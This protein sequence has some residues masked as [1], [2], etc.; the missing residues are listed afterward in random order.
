[1]SGFGTGHDLGLQPHDRT[2][3]AC[4][5]RHV[6][7]VPISLDAPGATG[8]VAMRRRLIA[9]ISTGLILL[10]ALMFWSRA[11]TPSDGTVVQLSNA[12]FHSDRMTLTFVLD[13]GT[14]LRDGDVVTAVDGIP[15][16]SYAPDRAGRKGDVLTYSVLRHGAPIHVTIRLGNFPVLGFLARSW[17]SLA[18]LFILLSMAIFV[19]HRRAADPAAQ[20]LILIASLTFCGT[21][22]WLLG[23]QTFRLAAHGPTP[24]DAVGELSLAMIWG[25]VAH[26]ALVAPATKLRVSWWRIT[27]LYSLPLVLYGIYL[28]FALPAAHDAVEVRGRIAQISL[29]PSSVLPLATALLLL[30]SYR[31]TDDA[32]SRQRMRWLLL[33]LLAAGL[34]FLT[35]WTIPNLMGWQVPPA[36]LIALLWLPP[37]LAVGAAIL[38]YR[39]FDIEVIVRRSLLYA[40]LT[41]SVVGI[42]LAGAWVLSRLFT[43]PGLAALLACGLVGF[44]APPLHSFLRRRV[45]RLVYGER[46][47]PF[48]VLARLGR[49]DVGADP[50]L[51]LQR[52]A[53][54]LAQTLRLPFVAIELRRAQSRFAVEASYGHDSGR[55]VT[56][57]LTLA[58]GALG[59]LILA[60]GPGREP[61]GPADRRLLD[62]LTR[63]VSRAASLVLLAT[64]LQ[65][66]REQIV[67]AR[68]EER[69]RLHHRLHD[70]LGPDLAAGV[71]RMEAARELIA[72]DADAAVRHLEE[73]IALTRSLIG[74]VRGLVYNL[75]PPALDQ[76]G[77]AGALRERTS[78]LSQ[79]DAPGGIRVLIQQEG[80]LDDLPAAV[81]VA[82]FWI[83]VE[84][85]S[86]A[87]RH[88]QVSSCWVCL[89]RRDAVLSIEIRDDGRGL[90]DRV[91][92][93]GGL[94]S[95]RER[96][97][98]LGGTCR[99]RRGE[100]GGTV[101]EARLPIKE[102]KVPDEL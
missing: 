57:P 54:T 20:A 3:S 35:I 87:I 61:F 86:N 47:D 48:E 14:G 75:R 85:V 96:T 9:A 46:D 73:Q 11:V 84:A 79:P 51:V 1:M 25:A 91:R 33:T 13:A 76:L 58:D 42:Y 101:V 74:D 100:S 40:S 80:V 83:G 89:S 10:S 92:A 18:V 29:L 77:L 72:R 66:S 5:P 23:D 64:E 98:E 30:L 55:S 24:L 19:F 82:A 37:T 59:R 28:A 32:E 36:N 4:Q 88:A 2:T 56:V 38:R 99:V 50:R 17:T 31:A 52:V 12:P 49:I 44:I 102:A 21:L 68:E 43:R 62:T 16:R 22:A 95:M 93:G 63:Q 90:P 60:V 97:E 39:M 70:G 27:A 8:S 94:I 81:E 7:Q 41:V 67:L 71:M 45:G 78:Q 15:L 65:Q 6:A 26:F 69:R 53:E 34:A